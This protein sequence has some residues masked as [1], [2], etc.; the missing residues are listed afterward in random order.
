MKLASV[1]AGA[2][3][4]ALALTATA[5]SASGPVY[6]GAA[7]GSFNLPLVGTVNT[8]VKT[9]DSV[10]GIQ[11]GN[12]IVQALDAAN[13]GINS[14]VALFTMDSAGFANNTAATTLSNGATFS[15]SG[16][17]SQDCA[18]YTGGTNTTVDFGQ[19]GI[20]TSDNNP[21]AAFEMVGNDR[22]LDISSNLAGC[23]T[24]NTVTFTKTDLS[25]NAA[26]GFDAAQ[27]TNVIPVEL[28]AN[29]TAG[30]V[31][32]TTNAGLVNVS[33]TQA[34]NQASASTYGAWKSPLNMVVKMKNP[35]KGLLAGTYNGTVSLTIAVAN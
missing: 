22:T 3:A 28:D 32:A 31:G 12:A 30:G 17:V 21:D 18:Y 1:L 26:A 2:T 16:T 20:N 4:V 11:Y 9:G 13:P 8:T 24:K 10:L 15:L 35:G 25:T 19:I 14:N 29:F 6:R 5:A 27:F 33:L 7:T 23:N 34:G